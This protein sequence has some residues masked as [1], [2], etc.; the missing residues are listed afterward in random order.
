MTTNN[1][2]GPHHGGSHVRV[3]MALP[4]PAL[5]VV[6]ALALAGCMAPPHSRTSVPITDREDLRSGA[7]EARWVMEPADK[8]VGSVNRVRVTDLRTLTQDGRLRVMV[9][10]RNER[11]RRDVIRLRGRWL[12]ASG[13]LA[14]PLGEWHTLALEGGQEQ[15]LM[16]PAP[17]GQAADFRIEL[18]SAD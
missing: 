17:V 3:A 18:S 1:Q 6:V 12:D 15:V 16:L 8:V 10:L 2:G 14:A 9:T 5:L 11:G 7:D 13:V 4:I